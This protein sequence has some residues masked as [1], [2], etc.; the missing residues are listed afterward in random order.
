MK[1]GV[2]PIIATVILIAITVTLA[3]IIFSSSSNFI[4]QLAPA[5]NCES[6]LF[7]AGIYKNNELYFLEVNNMGNKVIEGFNLVI[8][9]ESIGQ[10]DI[11]KIDLIVNPGTS[12]SVQINVKDLEGKELSL[13]PIIKNA[14]GTPL[15]CEDSFAKKLNIN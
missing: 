8:K 4:T 5:P 14:E 9:D 2:S 6:V 15:A 10:V 7:E 11:Q 12:V 13:I 3:F 1:K